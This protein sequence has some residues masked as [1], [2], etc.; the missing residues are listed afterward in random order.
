MPA[1]KDWPTNGFDLVG[2]GRLVQVVQDS[3]EPSRIGA[4]MPRRVRAMAAT[5]ERAVREHGIS[6]G[7]RD[8]GDLCGRRY[9]PP[10]ALVEEVMLS[11]QSEFRLMS[12][13]GAG[14]LAAGVD[15]EGGQVFQDQ[16]EAAERIVGK[17][18]PERLT[19]VGEDGVD[20]GGVG[21]ARRRT[22]VVKYVSC[23]VGRCSGGSCRWRRRSRHCCR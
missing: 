10:A 7:A 6:P 13:L 5:G 16:L 17:V 20:R 21:I 3:T 4:A 1:M 12:R 23:R 14:E 2:L 9:D 22:N 8:L 15:I 18:Q 19:V 11:G